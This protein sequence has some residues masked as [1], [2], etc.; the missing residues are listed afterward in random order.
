MSHL[1]T[2]GLKI[3]IEKVHCLEEAD[4]AGGAAP[5][6]W[7]LFFKVDGECYRFVN[8]RLTGEPVIEPRNF[9]HGNLG[10]SESGDTVF[11][12]QDVAVPAEV[13]TWSTVLRPIE[14]LGNDMKAYA[15]VI[16]ALLEEDGTT[17]AIL[18]KGYDKLVSG[19]RKELSNLVEELQTIYITTGAQPTDAAI[20]ERLQAIEA[21]LTQDLERTLILATLFS[22]NVFAIADPDQRIG[23]FVE[24]VDSDDFRN[25]Q[26]RPIYHTWR[27]PAG[28]WSLSGSVI[29]STNMLDNNPATRQIVTSGAAHWI[30]PKTPGHPQGTEQVH[31][32]YQLHANGS[33]W[34]YT[35]TPLTGWKRI[36]N[37]PQTVQISAD[38]PRLYQ[39]HKTGSI[40][41]RT[42]QS[43]WKKIDG[44]P[45]TKQIAAVSYFGTEKLYQLHDNG[46]V[47]EYTGSATGWVNMD[48]NPDTVEIV[49]A[50]NTVYQRTST[51]RI[52]QH[53]YSYNSRPIPGWKELDKPV[54]IKELVAG[55]GGAA[56]TPYIMGRDKSISIWTGSRWN[57]LE[58]HNIYT[59]HIAA[60]HDGLFR[61]L[62][63]GTVQKFMGGI[64][65]EFAGFDS[66]PRI[67]QIVFGGNN[68]YELDK[69]GFIWATP[70]RRNFG[71]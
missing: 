21:R 2:F 61:I 20:E 70:L 53:I 22:F 31:K 23:N 33:I 36:G 17:N 15:G 25:R 46:S 27:G 42:N 59:T 48:K 60:G 67:N 6:L 37:N 11:P 32:L 44:N 26:V 66:K 18:G 16:G 34:E 49:A 55:T 64:Y 40:W 45:H 38:G 3:V 68:L 24:R 7:A 9:R 62:S 39:L 4:D 71:D 35:G 8:G 14:V 12:F 29:G 54:D 1:P 57:R 63:D 47:W 50:G 56:T 41:E 43:G 69:D 65:E 30:G 10:K 58:D 52:F 51:G 28:I 19:L 13:G 5:Y